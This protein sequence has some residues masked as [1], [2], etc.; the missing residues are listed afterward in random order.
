VNHAVALVAGFRQFM[1]LPVLFGVQLGVLDHALHFR[2]AEA[3]RGLDLDLV[4]LAS[5]LVLG[6]NM[7]NSIGVNIE[8]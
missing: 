8:R 1:R 3:R 4:L 2:L 7:Q 6:R 5:G